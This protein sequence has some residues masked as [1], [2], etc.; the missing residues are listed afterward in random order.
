MKKKLL[1]LAIASTSVVA[2]ASCGESVGTGYTLNESIGSTTALQWN[3]LT[4]ETSDDS[5]ALG[6]ISSTLYDYKINDDKDGWEVVNEM[7]A[8]L[9]VDVTSEYV[10]QFGVKEGETAKAWRIEI[11][12]DAK[13]DNGDPITA[14]DYIYTMQQQ[15]DPKQM[16]RRAD[17]FYSGSFNIV[18]AKDYLYAG[19]TVAFDNATNAQ[20]DFASLVKNNDGQYATAEGDLVWV[21]IDKPL[22]ELSNYT[23]ASWIHDDNY[24]AYFDD[25]N[26]DALVALDT[27]EDGLVALTD[28]S[29]GYLESVV[30]PIIALGDSMEAF[31]Y[32]DSTFP[33]LSWDKVGFQKHGD[34]EFDIV[35]VSPME[36]PVD[37]YL[38]YNFSSI[39][40]VHKDTYEKAW[41]TQK[42][43][44]RVNRYNKEVKYTRSYGPYKL[45]YFEDGKKVKFVKNNEWYGYKE[46]ATN[47]AEAHVG[48]Y[49]TTQIVWTV[50]ANHSSE[51]L[52][53]KKGK[54]DTVGLQ[55]EDLETYGSSNY[56]IY[57][58]QSYTT[59]VSFNTDLKSLQKMETEKNDGKNRTIQTVKEF[60]EAISYMIDRNYFASAFTSA[61]AAG[62]GMINYMYQVF[63]DDGTTMA[64]RDTDFAKKALVDL[65]GIE[66]GTGKEYATL[67]DAYKAMTGY[68]MTKAKELFQTAYDK[69]VAEGLL[70]ANQEVEIQFNMYQNDTIY[71]NMLAYFNQQIT[72]ATKGT[73]L[74]GKVSFKMYVDEDYYNTMY[75]GN[76]QFIYT[77]WGGSTYGAFG[78]L[79]DAYCD[80]S[81]GNGNQMEIGYDT[82]KV[83]VDI[84]IDGTKYTNSLQA[85]AY[86]IAGDD[87]LSASIVD[88]LGKAED[89]DVDTK[90]MVLATL[91]NVYLSSY[92][93]IPVYYRQSASLYSKKINYGTDTYIDLVGFGGVRHIT[94]NY[95]DSEWK[96]FSSKA[97]NMNY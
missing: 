46:G 9:P 88:V 91:E 60:R 59:K 68:D 93:T 15:L 34:Y 40:L 19:Q 27:D 3:P 84:T 79:H 43:G 51:L 82:S 10:G 22:A 58:P 62:F 61:A 28:T 89:L 35:L 26:W 78:L 86:W 73:S 92:V 25:T 41:K 24:A 20:V 72:A 90:C 42:D 81:T 96:S 54:I 1:T 75:A 76:A 39:G 70:G 50:I 55:A 30:A 63:N 97:S 49:Q 95:N 38:P 13:W 69:A 83:A 36:K 7:A 5:S 18:N 14:D 2:L 74:E 87:S 64:Y 77:T 6:Y 80:D 45:T 57:T 16:N 56:L 94:Y 48:Q 29:K 85:W 66:Y 65:Y 44:T 4:W 31:L 53:F 71:Q 32:V 17:S 52:A 33:E 21:A 11:N 23:I 67:N 8:A 47:G 37:F 12:H